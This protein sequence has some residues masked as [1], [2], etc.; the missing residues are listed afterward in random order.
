M[1]AKTRH[2]S[3]DKF[4]HA[5]GQKESENGSVFLQL[6]MRKKHSKEH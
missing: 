5:P 1:N 2:Y 6:I 3:P 4:N